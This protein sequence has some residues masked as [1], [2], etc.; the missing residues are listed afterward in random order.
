MICAAG[1]WAAA[2]LNWPCVGTRKIARFVLRSAHF[3][4][5]SKETD[6]NPCKITDYAVF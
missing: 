4:V 3:L 1:R 2:R 5:K 6:N